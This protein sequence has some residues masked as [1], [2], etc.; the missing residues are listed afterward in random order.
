MWD[1]RPG[2]APTRL[3]ADSRTGCFINNILPAAGLALIPEASSGCT[4]EFPVQAS[5]AYAPAAQAAPTT[6]PGTRTRVN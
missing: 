6:R 1:L 4:C 2:Q 3:N 5:M